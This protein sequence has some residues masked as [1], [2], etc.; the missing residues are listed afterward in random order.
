MFEISVHVW[1][2]GQVFKYTATSSDELEKIVN[3]EKSRKETAAIFANKIGKKAKK[4][5]QA[6]KNPFKK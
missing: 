4:L 5:Y 3:R 1:T 2:S 6:R